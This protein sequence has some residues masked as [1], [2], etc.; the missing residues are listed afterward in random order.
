MF[1]LVMKI[2][3]TWEEW[4]QNAVNKAIKRRNET[5]PRLS[6]TWLTRIIFSIIIFRYKSKRNEG[7]VSKLSNKLHKIKGALRAQT[8]D[9]H[10]YASDATDVT[11]FVS[12]FLFSYLIDN[13]VHYLTV[14]QIS[15]GLLYF[16]SMFL[17]LNW[18]KIRPKIWL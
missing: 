5:M 14:S 17:L 18:H 11:E 13:Y 12:D 10:A 4:N 15:N 9:G 1:L 16:S 6:L 8:V 7:A 2:I 3:I